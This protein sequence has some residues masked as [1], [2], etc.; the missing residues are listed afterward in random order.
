MVDD[1]VVIAPERLG[2][3]R[4]TSA[5][6]CGSV[7]LPAQRVPAG[8]EEAV[9]E[10]RRLVDDRI[11][12]FVYSTLEALV[13]GCGP[14]QPWVAVDASRIDAVQRVASADLMVWDVPLP[15]EL[16]H[17]REVAG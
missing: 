16:R 17:R 1:H 11:A 12:L 7:F 10:V 3:D 2:H 6:W 15:V 14:D 13:D 8:A 9:L 5:S 4:T